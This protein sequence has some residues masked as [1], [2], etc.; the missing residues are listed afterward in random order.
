LNDE[1]NSDGTQNQARQSI[2]QQDAISSRDRYDRTNYYGND[3][4]DALG[5]QGKAKNFY[6][7]IRQLFLVHVF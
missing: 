2:K 4:Q 7:D 5:A 1:E 6:Q 3:V